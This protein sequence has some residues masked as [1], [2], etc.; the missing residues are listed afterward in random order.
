M[1]LNKE[2]YEAMQFA[3]RDSLGDNGTSAWLHEHEQEWKDFVAMFM[4][5][6][7]H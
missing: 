7:G 3:V 4:A 2:F 1:I 5:F 6:D